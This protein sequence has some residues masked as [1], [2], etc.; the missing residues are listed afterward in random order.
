MPIT[1]QDACQAV[2]ALMT[3]ILAGRFDEARELFIGEVDTMPLPT[4]GENETLTYELGDPRDDGDS[5]VVPV[6]VEI[7]A[8]PMQGKQTLSFVCV[9]TDGGAKIDMDMT[10]RETMGASPADLVDAVAEAARSADDESDSP[11]EQASEEELNPEIYSPE[12]LTEQFRQGLAAIEEQFDDEI[13][14]ITDSLDS[15][16]INLQIGW[17]T[18]SEDQDCPQRLLGGVFRPLRS[19]LRALEDHRSEDRDADRDASIKA[20]RAGIDT[21]RVVNA[22]DWRLCECTLADG[23]LLI[24]PCLSPT[25]NDSAKPTEAFTSEQIEWVIRDTLDLDISP[26]IRR[27]ESAVEKFV[28]DCGKRIGCT[29]EVIVDWDSFRA[30]PTGQDTLDALKRL[31]DDLLY[32]VLYALFHLRDKAPLDTCLESLCF[33]H[34]ADVDQRDIT[35]DGAGI[36][37]CT[38]LVQRSD[39]Y[40]T[41]AIQNLLAE[42]IDEL[43]MP[44]AEPAEQPEPETACDDDDSE[45]IDQDQDTA[46]SAEPAEPA[47]DALSDFQQ[48]VASME[49]EMMGPMR[50]QMAGL[51]GEGFTMDVDWDSLG[52]DQDH[53]NLVVSGVLGAGMGALMMMA[54]DPA[55]KEPLIAAVKGLIVRYDDAAGGVALSIADGLLTITCS[56][57]AG[58]FVQDPMAMGEA[59]KKL[60]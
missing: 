48:T 51:F 50:D 34:V 2:E 58:D 29:P 23:C 57:P 47:E 37:F 4:G 49:S 8:P 14:A 18:M 25:M 32:S 24:M 45:Q 16:E 27:T 28:A 56:G 43:P 10:M 20:V 46:P 9:E 21:I 60:L 52:Q 19:A 13:E 44:Q 59:I 40:T 7:D 41:E 36:T 55:V 35:V 38:P 42:R 26:A 54:Y 11:F 12:S 17:G 31:R 1:K 33:R 39:C 22:N 15:E 30:I 3:H 53:F 6:D 5:V